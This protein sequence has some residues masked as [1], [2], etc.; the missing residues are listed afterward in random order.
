MVGE[1]LAS[2]QPDLVPDLVGQRLG[3]DDQRVD[4]RQPS[5][6]A[7]DRGGVAL[8]RA[9]DRAGPDGSPV[10]G[11]P[12]GVDRL[13]ARVLVQPHAAGDRRVGQ[14][15]REPQGVDRRAVRRVRRPEGAGRGEH[16]R[17]LVG[18][19][20]ADVVLAPPPRP[21]VLDVLAGP[22]QLCGGAD[23]RDR[24]RPWP[25]GRRSPRRRAPGR[26][27]RPCRASWRAAPAPRSGRR[28]SPAT[29]G[30]SGTA[31]STIRRCVRSRRS[32][33]SRPRAP[34]CAGTARPRPGSRRSTGPVNPA[35][36]TATSTSRSPGSA[37]WSGAAGAVSAQREGLSEH[38]TSRSACAA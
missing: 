11:D 22:G 13:H 24:C 7:G 15:A 16:R 36:T 2:T 38:P 25:S 10:G 9:Q 3:G 31:P 23:E 4:R 33:R 19:E 35:P 5:S 20:E 32:P 21:G 30:T 14:A 8:G 1:R 37:G 28:G 12:T 18:V 29:T 27:R 26:P 17:R 34:R 6:V